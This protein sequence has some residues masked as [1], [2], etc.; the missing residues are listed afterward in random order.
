[1]RTAEELRLEWAAS[2]PMRGDWDKVLRGK[3]FATAATLVIAESS[4]ASER[5]PANAED[6][7][8]ARGLAFQ[9]GVQFAI[10]RMRS[11]T[12]PAPVREPE[13]EPY[14]HIG[15]DYFT[16]KNAIT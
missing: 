7:V 10:Q 3:A 12:Q 9:K 13:P 15:S 1:M 16:Q 5:F 14:G 2:Q 6:F 8:L 4:E 11:L